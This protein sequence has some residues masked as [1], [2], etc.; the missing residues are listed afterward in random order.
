MK[1]MK[2]RAY[3]CPQSEAFDLRLEGA[4]LGLSVD[5]GDEPVREAEEGSVEG[6][7]WD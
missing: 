3:E 4:I 2:K 5:G 1:M 7:S 6:W